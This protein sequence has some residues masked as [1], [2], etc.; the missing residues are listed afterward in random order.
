MQTSQHVLHRERLI[1]LYEFNFLIN[2]CFKLTVIEALKEISTPILE[3][4][5]FDN[6]DIWDF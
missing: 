2:E 1:V 4:L 3:D 6:L 5:R